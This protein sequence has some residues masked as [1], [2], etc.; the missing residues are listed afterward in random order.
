MIHPLN[1]LGSRDFC[2]HEIDPVR[3]YILFGANDSRHAERAESGLQI[4]ILNIIPE[5]ADWFADLPG[6]VAP[7]MVF[8]NWRF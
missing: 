7:G 8:L 1:L 6:E 4:G 5:T 3:S 2:G